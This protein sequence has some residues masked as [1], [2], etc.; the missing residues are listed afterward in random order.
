MS[1]PSQ[2]GQPQNPGF[3]PQDQA[4]AQPGPGYGPGYAAAQ[5][6]VPNTAPGQA[7]MQAAPGYAP[8]QPVPADAGFGG[9]P[10]APGHYG[11]PGNPGRHGAAG[12]VDAAG[13]DRFPGAKATFGTAL[14]SEWTKIRTVRS[15][16]WTLLIT[17][18][19][20]IGLS[21]LI[22]FGSS[23][24]PSSDGSDDWTAISMSGLF[25]GQLV[26]VVFGAMAITAEYSTGMIRTSLTS[27]P[28][29]AT[30]FWAKATIVTA[31]ALAVGLICSFVSFFIA[32]GIYSGHHIHV[33]LG[34]HGV[35]RAVFGGGLYMAGTALLAFGLGAI[36]R[37]TAGAITSSVGVLFILFILV[38]FLPG[39]WHTD[40]AKWIPFNAGLQI[41]ATRPA[42]DMLSPW[43][44]FG[45]FAAYAAAAV[46][47]GAI[48]MRSKDA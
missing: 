6:A 35:L 23:S 14:R 43:A 42:D 7:P 13:P 46:I 3:A 20:T 47:G 37:H 15:T 33:A 12:Q 44:G 19:L 36:L 17:I 34:D 5:N 48:V 32:S 16:F 39:N 18:V 41:I 26:I 31:V 24:H 27:Q 38:Q 30:L 28:R 25:F 11:Q 10:G 45:V 2:T 22:A 21:V 40:I 9:Q 1:T 29:R 8:G 4:A